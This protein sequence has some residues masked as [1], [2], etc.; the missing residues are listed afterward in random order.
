MP[1][2]NSYPRVGIFQDAHFDQGDQED[3]KKGKDE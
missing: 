2:A 3:E 1:A